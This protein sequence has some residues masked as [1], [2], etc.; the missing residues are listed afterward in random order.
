MNTFSILYVRKKAAKDSSLAEMCTG[1][2][3]RYVS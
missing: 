2:E 1:K 3:E